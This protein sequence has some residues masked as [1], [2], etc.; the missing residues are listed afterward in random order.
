MKSNTPMTEAERNAEWNHRYQTRLAIL[1][2]GP[3]EPT[4]GMIE[5]AS[6]EANEWLKNFSGSEMLGGAV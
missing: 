3:G 5:I 2:D 4:P 1:M 6:K